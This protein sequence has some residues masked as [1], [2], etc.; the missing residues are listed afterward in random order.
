MER[1]RE[2]RVPSIA[3]RINRLLL[4]LSARSD[5]W[6]E[7]VDFSSPEYIALIYG[8]TFE[9]VG[10]VLTYLQEAG[11]VRLVG[12]YGCYV[13]LQ[14]HMRAEELLS[15]NAQSRQGFVAMKYSEDMREIYEAALG[16]AIEDAGFSPVVMYNVEH[17]RDINDEMI[18]QLRKSRFVVADLTHQSHGA[19]FEA[20]YGLALGVPVII[21][22]RSTHSKKIHFDLRQFNHL[23]WDEPSKLRRELSFRIQRVVGEASA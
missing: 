13:T 3:E 4:R 20:G 10:L 12:T 5:R 23:P 9:D 16:P 17:E 7:E 1:L 2:L 11:Y 14:G 22:C 15:Q 8:H 21:T 6:K 18:V 19:Y